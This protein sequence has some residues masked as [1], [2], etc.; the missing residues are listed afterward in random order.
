VI[1]RYAPVPECA[2]V[3]REPFVT[4]GPA[5]LVCVGAL[6]DVAPVAWSDHELLPTMDDLGLSRGLV[7]YR[8]ELEGGDAPAVLSFAEVR[9]RA[10]VSLDGAPVGTANEPGLLRPSRRRPPA[11]GRKGSS[12]CAAIRGTASTGR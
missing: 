2:R 3:E 8:R 12:R 6:A 9:D 4:P 5:P 1:S 7:R 10:W 11:A